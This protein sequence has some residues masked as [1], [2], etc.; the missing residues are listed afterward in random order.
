LS[1]SAGK[2]HVF[3]VSGSSA[4]EASGSPYAVAQPQNLAVL[5]VS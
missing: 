3:T 4:V 2:L 1:R 5:P